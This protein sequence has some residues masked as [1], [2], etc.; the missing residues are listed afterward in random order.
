MGLLQIFKKVCNNFIFLYY[1]TE[2][3]CFSFF[4]QQ[5]EFSQKKYCNLLI[6]N[7]LGL[8]LLKQ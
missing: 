5:F 4:L 2:A 1:Q 8:L 3:E 6:I 7:K